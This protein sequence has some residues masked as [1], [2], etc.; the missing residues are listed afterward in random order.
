MEK[1]TLRERIINHEGS[2]LPLHDVVLVHIERVVLP[3]AESLE[4]AK[5]GRQFRGQA[6]HLSRP[7]REVRPPPP[8]ALLK[9]SHNVAYELRLGAP[10]TDLAQLLNLEQE[11]CN[12]AAGLTDDAVVAVQDRLVLA[13]R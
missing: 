3:L 10:P 2:V 13:L 5:E 1:I 4:L 7:M 9:M 11:E 8:P 6:D 12:A